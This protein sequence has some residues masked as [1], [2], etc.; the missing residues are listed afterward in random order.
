MKKDRTRPPGRKWGKM[1]EALILDQPRTHGS[2][3][4][5]EGN[6]GMLLNPARRTMI[7]G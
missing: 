2:T 7:E 5:S 4:L 1:Q 3:L 6:V